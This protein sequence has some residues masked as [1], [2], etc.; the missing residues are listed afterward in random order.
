MALQ[1]LAILG[2]HPNAALLS[3]FYHHFIAAIAVTVIRIFRICVYSGKRP[4]FSRNLHYSY[5]VLQFS[6]DHK[7]F[8][9]MLN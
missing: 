6:Y 8:L 3:S 5:D 2:V 1:L 9:I 7:E 4:I